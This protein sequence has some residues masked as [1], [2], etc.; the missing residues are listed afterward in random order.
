MRGPPSKPHLPRV[1]LLMTDLDIIKRVCSLLGGVKPGAVKPSNPRNKLLYSCRLAGSRAVVL[2]K[3][4]RP[5]MGERRQSQIEQ[6]IA[7]YKPLYKHRVGD[8]PATEQHTL[9]WLSGVLEGEGSFMAGPPSK[10]RLPRISLQMTDLDVMQ[11]IGASLGVQPYLVKRP[12]RPG[13]K[14]IY[15]CALV[16][17]RAVILMKQLRCLMGERR[18]AQIDKALAS[19][20]LPKDHG[21]VYPTRGQLLSHGACSTNALAKRYGVSRYYIDKVRGPNR[22]FYPS[23]EQLLSHGECSTNALARLYN[24]SWQYVNNTRKSFKGAASN[25]TLSKDQEQHDK[26]QSLRGAPSVT[27]G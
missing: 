10:P 3:R 23:R 2:M 9:S 16:G 20:K 25:T 24:V 12:G 7:S 1:A 5:L 17:S 19:Y 22:K 18:Q 4:L 26:I 13:R 14:P 6:A 21:K 15:A 11:K 8:E 27:A